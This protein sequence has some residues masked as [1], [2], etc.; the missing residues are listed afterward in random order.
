MKTDHELNPGP[1]VLASV[2][3]GYPDETFLTDIKTLLEDPCLDLSQSLDLGLKALVAAGDQAVTDL[4]SEYLEIFEMAKQPNPL[5]ETEYGRE[6]AMFKTRELSDIAGF[7]R[8]FGFDLDPDGMRE[9][10]DHVSVELEFYSLMSMKL[11]H[12]MREKEQEGVEIVSDAMQKF[13]QEHLGRFLPAILERPGVAGS[14]FYHSVFAWVGSLIERECQRLGVS[15]EKAS[16][17]DAQAETEAVC[18]SVTPS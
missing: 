11:I 1:F 9:M 8:A 17:F 3:T 13:M 16:W 10:V 2:L 18:C 12:L 4:R 7:Y 6:R 14:G 5:Y 15:P